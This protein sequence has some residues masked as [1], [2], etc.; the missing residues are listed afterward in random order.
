MT[1]IL[2]SAVADVAAA[3]LAA[4]TNEPLVIERDGDGGV[5]FSRGIAATRMTLTEAAQQLGISRPTLYRRYID[6][7][8]L[9]V[10]DDG[11]IARKSLIRLI[12]D[13]DGRA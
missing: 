10:G 12:N 11:R 6:T 8:A 7:G 3:W 1:D 5:I 13:I 4:P 2:A 9:R